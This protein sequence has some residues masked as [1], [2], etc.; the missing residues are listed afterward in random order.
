VKALTDAI[1]E[2]AETLAALHD[3]ELTPAM[4]A[5]LREASFPACLGLLPQTPAAVA[6]WEAMAA[7]MAE[8]P[9]TAGASELD[10]LAAEYAA[11]YLTGAYG[12]S[13]CESVW[14]DE[15]HLTC[16]GAM[17][18]WRELHAGIGL[19]TPDWRQ[20]PDDHLVLQ[21]LHI[22]HLARRTTTTD[23]EGSLA[24]IL[25]EHTLRW[26]PQFAARV[27]ARS[28]SP[29][30]GALAVLTAAWLE[31]VRNPSYGNAALST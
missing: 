8:L 23:F 4:I 1:A 29:F 20:R 2:D 7:A 26:L 15:D 11:I 30:Y 18:Q 22:A 3:R 27:A 9:P 19:A 25:D 13:P 24:Q 21:L 17:F 31:T 16:Q 10:E 28:T 12:A 6:A 14:T 5:A